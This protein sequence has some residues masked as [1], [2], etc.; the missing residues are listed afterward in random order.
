[1]IYSDEDKVND[2]GFYSEPNFKPDFNYDLLNVNNY[3]CHLTVV[4][5]TLLDKVG[6]LDP[7]FDGAQDFDFVL[8]CS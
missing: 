6:M 3:I 4:K 2:E 8:R 1:M 7:K 5:R